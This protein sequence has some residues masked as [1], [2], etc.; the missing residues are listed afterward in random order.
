MIKRSSVLNH[1][2]GPKRQLEESQE[3]Y[4]ARRAQENREAKEIRRRGFIVW[5]SEKGQYRK[6]YNIDDVVS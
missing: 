2:K 1:W 3:A 6:E 5:N 4:K